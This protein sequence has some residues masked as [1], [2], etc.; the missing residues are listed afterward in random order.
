MS[1]MISF[2]KYDYN[3]DYLFFKDLMTKR[4]W[5]ALHTFSSIRYLTDCE[6]YSIKMIKNIKGLGPKGY[7]EL[8]K[9]CNDRNIYF[10]DDIDGYPR[11]VINLLLGENYDRKELFIFPGYKKRFEEVIDELKSFE[12]TIIV[13]AYKEGISY[14]DISNSFDNQWDSERVR[15][16]RDRTMRKLRNHYLEYIITGKD[17]DD[18]YDV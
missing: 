18:E 9:L 10:R 13:S 12:K 4:L 2:E 5:N 1:V 11:N 15:Q 6:T 14:I 7:S 16:I 17:L 3:I 8:K